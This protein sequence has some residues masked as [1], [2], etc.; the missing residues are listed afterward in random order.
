MTARHSWFTG[1][2]RKKRAIGLALLVVILALF[3]TFNRFPKLDVVG[4]DLDAVTAPQAQ[5]FQGFCIERDPGQSFLTRWFTFSI[6]YLRLVT[7]GMTFAFVVAGLAESML[8]PPGSGPMFPSGGTFRRTLSGAMTGPVMNLCS[9]CIVPV[10]SAFRRRGA[11]VDGA[12]AMVQGSATMNV[13]A[14]AMVFFVFTPLLGA[15]RLV[16]AVV[17][18]LLIGPLV[19]KTVRGEQWRVESEEIPATLHSSLITHNTGSWREALLEGVR[20]W[21]KHS[22]GYLVR[23]GPIMVVAGFAS[24]LALQWISPD[25]VATYLGNDLTGV[26]IAATFGILINVPL[27][28]E[29]PLVAL[30]LLMGMGTAPAA[31]L[32][33]T[34]AA[35]GPVTFWGLAKLMPR[36]A[37][38]TFAG[39]TWALGVLGGIAVL[40]IGAFV[41]T[42]EASDLQARYGLQRET[43]ANLVHPETETLDAPAFVD[44]TTDAGIDFL[45]TRL[46]M[47]AVDVGAGAVVFDYNSD[48]LHDI[49]VTSNNG[50]NA[51]YRNNGDGTFTD[52]AA[53]ANVTDEGGGTANGACAADYDNDGDPDLYVAHFG[54]SRLYR[55]DGD[56]FHRKFSNVTS[57]ALGGVKRLER[58]TGCAWGDYDRDGFL[59]LVVVSHTRLSANVDIFGV[60]VD[61]VRQ[62]PDFLELHDPLIL[63]HNS[64]DGTFEDR[65]HLLGDTESP[66]M[67][68]PLGNMWGSGFQ[69][70]WVDYDN[71][72]DPDL[73]VVND[74]GDQIHPNVL[75]R[76]D[77]PD[78]NA[79]AE[80]AECGKWTFT[81]VSETSGAGVE[82]FG[83]GL[84]VGDYDLDGLLDLFVTN[85]GQNILLNNQL[86]VVPAPALSLPNAGTQHAAPAFEIASV[87][88]RAGAAATVYGSGPAAGQ[89]VAWGTF[90]FDYDNDLDEDLYLV[91]GFL[92]AQ[93]IENP[94]DQPNVLLR[95]N[96]DGTFTDVSQG[97]GAD[98]PGVG[99]G[100]VYL[101]YDD[102]GCLD[103]FVANLRQK[104][105]LLRNVCD[106]GHGWLEIDLVGSVSNR[107]GIGA[108]V[109][110]ETPKATLIRE[111]AAGSSQIGQNMLTVHFGIG[112]AQKA[113]TVK[114]EWP[115]GSVQVFE[116][117]QANRRVTITEPD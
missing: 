93:N 38:A 10:S 99:R 105:K 62:D 23:L 7:V 34:A 112:Q 72:G 40:A 42:T 32:L 91:S 116:N 3:F 111:V 108:R 71:D 107:D 4:E 49:Y 9:A 60:P 25:V 2:I 114:V 39:A 78:P 63:Y 52:V 53:A 55:N 20:D 97:S 28:F 68:G 54:P 24:G 21:A 45:H 77:G 47:D 59:D 16:L 104:A 117:V 109:T 75:W 57:R 85:I 102:D 87:E 74:L 19:V 80:L 82:M 5:C 90:F 1:P 44:V 66:T 84:A 70:G 101:D 67:S 12:I 92:N 8:F 81:D 61:T 46:R 115:S 89:R 37:V 95:N 15:S 64:G 86:P 17:G 26:A 98:D 11:G 58:T 18:A 79:C 83:M 48:T 27:L 103:I 33:F 31:T 106:T 43:Y 96:G 6:T 113:D 69:P 88:A 65:S 100:G 13:P 41:W 76:N 14:L 30:L 36:R 56:G 51:L 29:I 22:L 94:L 50:P 73:Y 110:V 35:G